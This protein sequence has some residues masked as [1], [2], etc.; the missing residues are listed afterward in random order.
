MS[1]FAAGAARYGNLP[2]PRAAVMVKKGSNQT[3]VVIPG[4]V[5]LV[6]INA[7]L[8]AIPYGWRVVGPDGEELAPTGAFLVTAETIDP[9]HLV[10]DMY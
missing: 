8:L 9:Y 1:H 4:S 6:R 2:A 5:S 10:L 3:L 7:A